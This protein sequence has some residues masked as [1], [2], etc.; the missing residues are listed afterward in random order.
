MIAQRP[1][2][3]P[4]RLHEQPPPDG[5]AGEDRTQHEVDPQRVRRIVLEQEV[6]HAGEDVRGAE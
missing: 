3:P 1:G 5:G 6:R 4:V 2:Q